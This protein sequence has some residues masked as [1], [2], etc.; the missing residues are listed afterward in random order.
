VLVGRAVEL[1][2]IDEAYARALHGQPAVVLLAGEAGIGKTRLA[3]EGAAR[4]EAAGAR[5]LRGGCVQ[6]GGDGLPFAPVVDA[7]RTLVR[8]TP[9]DELERLLG[10]ARPDVARLL[11]DLEATG[12]P[13]PLEPGS[14]ARLF[15][16]VLGLVG[17]LAAQRPLLLVIEDLHWADR[18]TLDL[19]AFLVRALRSERVLTILTY[20]SDELHRRH[21][22]RP[23]LVELD[24]LGSV[25]RCELR[26]APAARLR[27]AV[28]E[29]IV[30]SFVSW[31]SVPQTP[32]KAAGPA[33]G[34][35]PYPAPT[36]ALFDASR[37]PR[38]LMPRQR[39]LQ[40]VGWAASGVARRR[41][42]GLT[43]DARARRRVAERPAAA[44]AACTPWSRRAA[45]EAPGRRPA[46]ATGV[47]STV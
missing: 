33:S 43:R 47:A 27:V 22:L 36:T 40:G 44:A 24:R 38:R 31:A 30:A 18:S 16:A 8:E 7:L 4:A 9:A 3:A 37:R 11:P 20:R 13:G 32:A 28:V 17:R 6:L 45:A 12:A 29:I 10:S 2:A 41:R 14:T 26:R 34:T 23:L 35:P 15:D 19:L 21:P 42:P 25:E 1:H 5:V 39:L 46:R